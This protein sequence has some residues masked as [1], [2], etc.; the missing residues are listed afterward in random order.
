[1]M[2]LEPRDSTVIGWSLHSAAGSMA[3][4]ASSG[5]SLVIWFFA[6]HCVGINSLSKV[7]RL[8]D[9]RPQKE[10]WAGS[11][12]VDRQQLEFEVV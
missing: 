9:S 11:I 1:M 4:L 12:E 5:S 2:Q 6:C 8:F 10:L 7:K 3:H